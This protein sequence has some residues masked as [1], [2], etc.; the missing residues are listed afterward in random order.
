MDSVGAGELPAIVGTREREM[1]AEPDF[2][3]A[4]IALDSQFGKIVTGAG[5]N[6]I[7]CP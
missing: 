2:S 3:N 5:S 4:R 7:L 6:S 1:T